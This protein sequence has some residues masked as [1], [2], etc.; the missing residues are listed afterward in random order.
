MKN[1]NYRNGFTLIETMIAVALLVIV[2]SFTLP[3]GFNFFQQSTLRD[4]TRILENSLKKAQAAAISQQGNSSAGIKITQ[5]N[6]TIF[7]GESYN[8]RRTALDTVIPFGVAIAF[9][10]DNEIVFQKGTG[11]PIIPAEN[12]NVSI[13]LTFGIHNNQIIINRFGKI[14]S[15]D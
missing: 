1:K 10:G 12:R 6:F 11:I 8:Q 4:Q 14:E 3:V 7:E 5:N 13:N 9:S 15:L 2:S